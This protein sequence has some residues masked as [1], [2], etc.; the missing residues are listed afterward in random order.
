MT[1]G[2]YMNTEAKDRT[3]DVSGEYRYDGMGQKRLDREIKAGLECVH[4]LT[5]LQ[6]G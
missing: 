1:D 6:H 4:L 3:R 5:A 2:N